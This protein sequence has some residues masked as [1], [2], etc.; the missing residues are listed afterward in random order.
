[1]TYVNK[2]TGEVHTG[3]EGIDPGFEHNPG[4]GRERQLRTQWRDRDRIFAGQREPDPKSTR[5]RESQDPG[6]LGQFDAA[7]RAID[8]SVHG[9]E[10]WPAFT[11]AHEVGHMLDYLGL[12]GSGVYE[13]EQQSTAQ[14]RD[15]QAAIQLL[16]DIR[17]AGASARRGARLPSLPR[18]AVGARL[19]PVGVAWRSGSSRLK[20]A[21]R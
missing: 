13:S 4:V 8:L 18:G 10:F 17:V 12:P 1:M 14:M 9:T 16:A 20:G 3:D 2:R 21:A 6:F 7:A 15:V 5:V 19:C 11:A